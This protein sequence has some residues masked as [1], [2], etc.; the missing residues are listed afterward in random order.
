VERT[1]RK[2]S[3]SSR[4]VRS[5]PPLT[6]TLGRSRAPVSELPT[7]KSQISEAFCRGVYPGDGCLTNSREGTEP[8][9]LEH[10]FKGKTDWRALSP[11]FIDQAP[12]GFGTALNFFSD[13]AFRFYL[14]AY[15]LADLDEKL[16]QTNVVFALT[17]GFDKE[18]RG[19]RINPQRYGERTWFE[20]ARHKFAM[21][22]AQ[23]SK[24]LSAISGIS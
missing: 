18:S 20:H 16:K 7:L 22:N 10:E 15:L 4:G 24:R 6:T 19:K 17:H 11:S 5:G 23:E 8:G 2:P 21:F 12:D 13:E 3:A 1:G 9:L 14:P